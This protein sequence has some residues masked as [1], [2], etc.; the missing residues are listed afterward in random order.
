MLKVL[1]CFT[2][3]NVYDMLFGFDVLPF[4]D[5]RH[6]DKMGNMR[7][8]RE[9]AQNAFEF[10]SMKQNAAAALENSIWNFMYLAFCCRFNLLSCIKS[11]TSTL[12]FFASETT[13]CSEK[14]EFSLLFCCLPLLYIGHNG[15]S[16]HFTEFQFS[17]RLTF[18]AFWGARATEPRREQN[19]LTRQD[20]N[21]R[22]TY[23]NIENKFL[24]SCLWPD[25]RS[26]VHADGCTLY[27][28]KASERE[29]KGR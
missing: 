4:I 6:S 23:N 18:S 20:Y 26:V 11:P 24:T 15:I 21:I 7:H 10:P 5:N 8:K 2:P 3:P 1:L 12:F 14:R 16:Q 17:T 28:T 9:S 29:K 22:E 27:S 13:K 25:R 19:T